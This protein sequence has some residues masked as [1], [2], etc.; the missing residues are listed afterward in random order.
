MFADVHCHLNGIRE[1]E[2][3]IQRAKEKNVMKIISCSGGLESMKQN[4]SFAGRFHGVECCLGIH[5]SD[6]LRMREKEI[7]SALSF[8]KENLSK[9]VAVGEIGLDFFHAKTSAQRSLQKKLFGEQLSI[10]KENSLPAEVHSRA[11]EKGVL[12]IL[13]SFAPS[14]TLLHWFQGS[15]KEVEKALEMGC[16]FSFTPSVLYSKSIQKT[17]EIVPLE[18]LMLETDSPV[19]FSG[20]PA[21]PSWIPGVGEKVAEVKSLS[22]EEVEFS[23]TENAFKFFGLKK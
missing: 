18:R 16:F 20:S 11:A 2:K 3:A 17:A 10:A 7:S 23:T 12:E 21:E 5:P 14:T 8:L 22:L 9:C 15:E 13:P 1:P 4:L 6:L 19:K